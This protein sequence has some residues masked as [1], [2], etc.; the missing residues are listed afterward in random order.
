MAPEGKG[1]ERGKCKFQNRTRRRS[2]AVIHCNRV[3]GCTVRIAAFGQDRF[4]GHQELR[5]GL[6]SARS[7]VTRVSELSRRFRRSLIVSAI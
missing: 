4:Q 1:R 3:N 5:F 2:E 7:A 6:L